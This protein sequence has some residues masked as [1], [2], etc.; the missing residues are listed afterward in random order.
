[1]SKS[2][3]TNW[4]FLSIIYVYIYIYR[5][6]LI[7]KKRENE[8]RNKKNKKQNKNAKETDELPSSLGAHFLPTR[9]SPSYGV[10]AH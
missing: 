4:I 1:L 3:Y 5:T 10:W 2:I 7:K 6:L 9:Y 8:F